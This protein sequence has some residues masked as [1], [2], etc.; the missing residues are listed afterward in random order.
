MNV[1]TARFNRALTLAAVVC[2]A[3]IVSAPAH[4]GESED[5]NFAKKLRRDGMYVA[6]AEEFLRFT[7][8]YP[9][10]PFRAEALFSA[11]E[12]YLQA[13]KANDALGHFS[14][15][16]SSSTSAAW[17]SGFTFS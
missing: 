14:C 5:L 2:A 16:M 4:A 8:K 13:A 1:W 6:A 15:K 12:S 7:E 10:S 17:V 9:Q 11:A 3:C